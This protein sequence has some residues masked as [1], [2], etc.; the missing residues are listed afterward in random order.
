MCFEIWICPLQVSEIYCIWRRG[1][2]VISGFRVLML[3][4]FS[5]IKTVKVVNVS[6]GAAEQDIEEF[7]SFSGDIE[8]VELQRS[9][10]FLSFLN[11]PSRLLIF[12]TF[13]IQI[14]NLCI[15]MQP[16]WTISNCLYYLQGTTGSWDCCTAFGNPLT[17][18]TLMFVIV[19][20]QI[21]F[22]NKRC[23]ILL[24]LMQH[25]RATRK[26]KMFYLRIMNSIWLKILQCSLMLEIF[27]FLLW[28]DIT[29]CSGI[30]EK[31]QSS[32]RMRLNIN[33][34]WFG[35]LKNLTDG[36]LN[37]CCFCGERFKRTV[38]WSMDS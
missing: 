32:S 29:F 7:F 33:G 38:I 36:N 28:I 6:L 34:V 10:I 5:Q 20:Y 9:V 13:V 14:I 3:V 8:Y 35:L 30:I 17:L 37:L 26:K 27:H 12:L 11:P 1:Y 23:H 22:N 19:S 15:L 25:H 24:N 21:C 18:I 4:F 2:S 16:W 31:V